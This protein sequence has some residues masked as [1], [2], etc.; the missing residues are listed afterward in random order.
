MA[1]IQQQMSVPIWN[2]EGQKLAVNPFALEK[3]EVPQNEHDAI[4]HGVTQN[5]MERRFNPY[6]FN[7]GT[8]LAIAGAD[9]SV[10]AGDTRMSTGYQILS[11]NVPKLFE[12]SSTC[13]MASSGCRT[14]VEA[15]VQ[16][17]DLKHQMYVHDNGGKEM[18]CPSFAQM[19]SVTLYGRRFFPYYAFNLLAGIDKNGKGVVYNYDAIG[20]MESVGYSACGSG[21]AYTIPLLD[22]VVGFRTRQDPTYV[23]TKEETIECVKQV[24][25]TAG[26][27]DIYT[28]DAVDIKIITKEGIETVTFQ[29]KKD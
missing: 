27:R 8:V 1:P 4:D 11:R 12:L 26:E 2:S 9:F 20:S 6:D 29:L 25:I 19:L 5:P 7:G 15:L 21:Q 18:T 10:I 13:V 22:N 17:L 28:G 23:M 24:F 14:D 3:G 16:N